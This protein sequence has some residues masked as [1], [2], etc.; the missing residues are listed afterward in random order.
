MGMKSLL[1]V[2]ALVA[3]ASLAAPASSSEPPASHY[4][5]VLEDAA[6]SRAVAR[7]HVRTAGA[8]V[9]HVYGHAL[10]G[11]AARLT[12]TSLAAVRADA[13]VRYVSPDGEARIDAQTLPT[14][15]DR[16]D[17]ELSSTLAGNGSGSVDVDVAV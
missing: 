13:R 7:E 10:K 15:I 9:S 3:A 2:A 8:E 12:P 6:N 16:I 11:Y 4:I 1:F 17:G 14:G 5:V